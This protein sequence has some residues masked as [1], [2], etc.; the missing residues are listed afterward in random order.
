MRENVDIPAR[1]KEWKNMA[2]V[3]RNDD[4]TLL[5]ARDV[6]RD[7]ATRNDDGTLVSFAWPGY[8]VYYVTEDGGVLC[9]DDA[10]MAEREGLTDDPQWHIV[11][12]DVNWEDAALICDH[13]G[14]GIGAAYCD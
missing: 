8:P 4:G 11:G 2:N 6:R 12:C 13:C 1:L 10:N 3:T 7:Y 14:N 5:I 9:P